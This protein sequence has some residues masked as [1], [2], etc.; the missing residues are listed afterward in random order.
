MT[1]IFL[2]RLRL[3]VQQKLVKVVPSACTSAPCSW[4]SAPHMGLYDAHEHRQ[5]LWG[6]PERSTLARHNQHFGTPHFRP[7]LLGKIGPNVRYYSR[8][9]ARHIKTK[10]RG[11]CDLYKAFEGMMR[12]VHLLA[13][14]STCG[15]T[16]IGMLLEK[17]SK[18]RTMSPIE[19]QF[20]ADMN[21]GMALGDS[22]LSKL[23][24][25]IN[26]EVKGHPMRAA[27]PSF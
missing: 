19:L 3:V 2:R 18:Y 11:P 17:V 22:M 26:I 24:Q 9:T 25:Q 13:S 4:T 5:A 27:A 1:S 23:N 10:L 15:P 8:R 6:P 20:E 16:K 7:N 21:Q 12:H 14:I